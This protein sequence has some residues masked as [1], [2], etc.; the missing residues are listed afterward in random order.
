MARRLSEA[1]VPE[2]LLSS[3]FD[4][5]HGSTAGALAALLGPDTAA[6]AADPPGA[7]G[8]TDQTVTA[9]VPGGRAGQ[10]P[11]LVSSAAWLPRVKAALGDFPFPVMV[12]PQVGD[13]G[14]APPPPRS[15]P[16]YTLH[17][18][19]ITPFGAGQFFASDGS[20]GHWANAAMRRVFGSV[21]DKAQ[22]TLKDFVHPSSAKAELRELRDAMQV[23][24]ALLIAHPP[25]HPFVCF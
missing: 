14:C 4:A 17:T 9:D 5:Y 13:H 8:H 16:S 10:G 21:C 3:D 2:F 12:F 25:H 20:V 1:F 24:R 15:L 6:A 22:P 19:H 23:V 11:L 7:A 18:H